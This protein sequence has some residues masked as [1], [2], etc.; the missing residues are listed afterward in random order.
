MR[1]PRLPAAR[2]AAA[3]VFALLYGAAGLPASPAGA[4]DLTAAQVEDLRAAR[5]GDMTKLAIHPEPRALPDLAVLAEDGSEMRLSDLAGKVT[6]LNLWAT[7]CAPC[8]HE[9]PSLDALKADA[10]GLGIEVVAL[11]VE[12]KGRIK[13]RRFFDNLGIDHL[14][15]ISDEDNVLP[16]RLG[17]IGFPVTLVLDAEG[18]EVARMQGDADWHGKDALALLERFA[19]EMGR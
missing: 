18:R 17:L 13:A 8:R 3:F 11:N 4:A 16:P 19:S 15:V 5:Q 7:W 6:V 14:S 12:R 1:L 9:M 10:E 2:L